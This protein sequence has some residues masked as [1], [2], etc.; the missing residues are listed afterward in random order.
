M[1]RAGEKYLSAVSLG[2][3]GALEYRANFFFSLLGAVAPVVIQT[4]LWSCLYAKDNPDS[5]LFGFT[6]SQ[7]L[8]YTIVA[9]IVNRLVRTGFEYDLNNDIHSGGLDRFLVKP[10]DYFGFRI[11]QF[12]GSK[13]A[14]SVFM[15]LALAAAL[16]IL[17]ALVGF[18]AS[19]EAVA[20]F[21]LALMLAFV[22]NFLIF[23][24]VG[25]LGFWLTEIGF[26]FEAARIVIITASGGIFPLSVFGPAE[27]ILN[28]L[29]FRYTI[30]FPTD[31]L[32]GRIA[33][34]DLWLGLA[35]AAFWAVALYGAARIIWAIG[36]KRFVALGS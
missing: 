15:G 30:Q 24:C 4:A 12:I 11:A 28:A 5:R 1:A 18:S 21:L 2:L 27:A 36:V 26:L 23:W 32:C 10:I 25:M 31:V 3:R 35:Q 16:G 19:V 34:A 13:T 29:P 6:F 20:G 17:S 22:L 33:G 8:A 7:M 9:N 14:E